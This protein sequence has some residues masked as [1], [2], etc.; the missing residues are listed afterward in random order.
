MIR[1]KMS[2]ELIIGSGHKKEQELCLWEKGRCLIRDI[3]IF[4][5]QPRV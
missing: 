1:M 5:E 3:S 2:E 4:L